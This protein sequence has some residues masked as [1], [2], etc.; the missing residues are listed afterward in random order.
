MNLKNGEVS[1]PLSH[2]ILIVD[3][4]AELKADQLEFMKEL[5]SASR[6]GHSLGVH[7]ILATQKLS[8][9]VNEKI[10]LNSRYKLCLKVQTNEDSN[11]VLK[12]PLV[13]EIKKP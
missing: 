4:F 11:E 10:W 1:K 6:I 2:L 8:V 3:E 9:Q 5:I 12:S 7:L 13:F